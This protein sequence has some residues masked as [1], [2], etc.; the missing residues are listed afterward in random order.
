M[1]ISFV[2]PGSSP[3]PTGGVKI[4]YEHANRLVARGH[5]VTILH[6]AYVTQKS[7]LHG[8]VRAAASYLLNKT[9]IMRWRPDRWF[10][11]DPRIRMLWAPNLSGCWL[12][13]ADAVIATSWQVAEWVQEYSAAKG[14][15]FYF[16]M[17]FERF[18]EAGAELKTRISTLHRAGLRTMV[19]S[20]AGREMVE[21]SD[22]APPCLVPCALEF[23][24]YTLQD[25]LDAESRTM[26]GFP[27]RPE[28]H[29][30]MND[31]V[32]ALAAA[33]ERS[34]FAGTIWSFG[35]APPD[36]LPAWIEYHPYPT[37]SQLAAL[38]NRTKI[39]VV[40]SL[41]E[42]WG[43]P[44][45][46]AMACGAA[47]VSTDNGGVRAYAEQGKSALLTPPGKPELLSGAISSLLEDEDYRLAIARAGYDS[48][49]QF[50]WERASG[51]LERCL[52]EGISGG[53]A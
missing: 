12:P 42:G 33:R 21:A 46:E 17:D 9:G 20:P 23:G 36:N 39:F 48:I 4:I 10:H 38:Y 32:E 45:S 53:A 14:K 28:R 16:A 52:E 29:K 11:V 24:V 47:L 27:A 19:I 41:Y 35:G 18:M 31:A 1:N 26:I 8:M 44:G 2:L 34:G 22:G 3:S 40:S 37:D 25:P 30:A 13:D 7:G 15:K 5:D 50:T 49:R 43:L 6:G 51:D